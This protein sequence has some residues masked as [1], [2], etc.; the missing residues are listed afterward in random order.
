MLTSLAEACGALAIGVVLTGM[1]ED[2]ARGLAAMRAAG[3]WTIAKDESTSVVY[4]MPAVAARLGS[5]REIL[6]LTSI[7]DALR[8]AVSRRGVPRE[9]ARADAPSAE[10]PSP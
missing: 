7:P 9:A 10:K 6:P 2:G 3:A 5:A 4:G 1:G 8:L